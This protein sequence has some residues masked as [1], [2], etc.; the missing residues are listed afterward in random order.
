MGYLVI[1]K[2]FDWNYLIIAI[3]LM[4]YGISFILGVEI[5]D[6]EGDIKG[7]KGTLIVRRGRPFGFTLMAI[8]FLMATLYFTIMAIF[9]NSVT[10]LRFEWLALLSLIPTSLGI[11]GLIKRPVETSIASKYANREVAALFL[12]VMLVDIFLIFTII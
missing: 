9:F 10:S 2:C 4:M 5:P 12:F 6:M 7:N 8:G 3:P 1:N 11:A